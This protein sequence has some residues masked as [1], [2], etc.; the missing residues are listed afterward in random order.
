MVLE[1]LDESP[2]VVVVNMNGSCASGERGR[3]DCT[4]QNRNS[5]TSSGQGCDDGFAKSLGRL[6][7]LELV[8]GVGCFEVKGMNITPTT[9]AVL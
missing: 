8:S 7:G 6:Q 2:L 9:A 4:G 5:N 3:P 1:G